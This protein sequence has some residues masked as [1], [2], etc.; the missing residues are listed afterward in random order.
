VWKEGMMCGCSGV[1]GETKNKYYYIRRNESKR[2]RERL[3]YMLK[4]VT[5][6]IYSMG[7]GDQNLKS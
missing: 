7:P 3:V 4:Y 5:K 6:G 2:E 1:V